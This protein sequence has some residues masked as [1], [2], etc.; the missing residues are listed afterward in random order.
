MRLTVAGR[1]APVALSAAWLFAA[2]PAASGQSADYDIVIRNG[3]VFD[4]GGNPWIRADVAIKN[5]RVARI[6]LIPGKGAK[7]IDAAGR[8]VS[9]GWIVTGIDARFFKKL[10]SE[11]LLPSRSVMSFPFI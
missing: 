3:R 4:G 5:G 11:M 7:E 8:Y 6:G 9:P 10:T 2:V 1:L